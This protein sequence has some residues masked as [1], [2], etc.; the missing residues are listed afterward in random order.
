M[1][2][3]KITDLHAQLMQGIDVQELS[4]KALLKYGGMLLKQYRQAK[5]VLRKIEP[6]QIAK[7]QHWILIREHCNTQIDILLV[8][9]NERMLLDPEL[10]ADIM[11]LNFADL[12]AAIRVAIFDEEQL[13]N[14]EETVEE[15]Q[16]DLIFD[17]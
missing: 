11:L 7:T 12:V 17:D 16:V 3:T 5:A 6:E 1:D 15:Q 9:L 13:D 2:I 8:E 4:D 14:K 10:F